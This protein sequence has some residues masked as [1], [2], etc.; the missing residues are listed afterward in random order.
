MSIIRIAF[1]LISSNDWMGGYNY[2]LS[3][4]SALSNYNPDYV[5]SVVFCGSDAPEEDINPFRSLKSIQIV[6]HEAFSKK[7]HDKGLLQAILIG[8]NLQVSKLFTNEKIDLIFEPARFYGWRIKQ[9]A[10]AWLPDFQHRHMPH[11]FSRIS[12]LKREIGFK[13]Q[14]A[15]GRT[16]LL[17]SNDA[18]KDC[19]RFYNIPPARIRILRFPALIPPKLFEFDTT[20]LKEIYQLPDKFAYIPNQ[21]WQHKNHL[22]VIEALSILKAK[23]ENITVICTGNT[24][25]PRNA[26]HFPYLQSRIKEL[27][28]EDSFRIL[29]LIPREHAV[30]LLRTCT[31]LVNPS[32]F[33]GWNTSVEEAKILNIPMLLSSIGVHQE[34]AENKA[35]YFDPNSSNILAQQLLKEMNHA[36]GDNNRILLQ[37]SEKVLREFSSEFMSITVNTLNS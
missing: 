16:I 32:F 13:I 2:L 36:K 27:Q 37:N 29:G 25:D 11:L 4:V 15:A 24:N 34:Q 33:E 1:P 17:S 23:G 6:K 20:K 26:D 28:L 31:L 10:I 14:I 7:A 35:I 3:L 18:S 30:G 9:P 12:R 22:I 19:K 21:F 5:Q 8:K